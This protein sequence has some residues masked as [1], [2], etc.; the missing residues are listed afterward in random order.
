LV[1]SERS[2]EALLALRATEGI[3]FAV[4]IGSVVALFIIMEVESARMP[5]DDPTTHLELTMIHEVMILDHSGPELAAVQASA[6]MKLT[7]GLGIVATLL[8]PLV[9]RTD[10]LLAEAANL[11]LVAVLAIAVGTIESLVARLKLRSVPQY[12]TV[13]LVG[14]GVAL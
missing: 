14:A 11:L 7:I 13:A 8:N 4:W 10:A 3:A 1:T 9:G 2:F 12:I 5:I 6:A